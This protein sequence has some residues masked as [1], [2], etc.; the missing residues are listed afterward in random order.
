MPRSPTSRRRRCIRRTAECWRDGPSREHSVAIQLR[1]S[2]RTSMSMRPGS[3]ARISRSSSRIAYRSRADQAAVSAK[4]TSVPSR[5]VTP[6]TLGRISGARCV[7]NQPFQKFCRDACVVTCLKTGPRRA[8]S[9][10]TECSGAE[11]GPV[12]LLTGAFLRLFRLI[13]FGILLGS[14]LSKPVERRR[15]KAT[16]LKRGAM[17]AGLPASAGAYKQS[18]AG[19]S[20]CPPGRPEKRRLPWDIIRWVSGA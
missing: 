12:L 17:T 19:P 20:R 3:A 13:I 7:D 15:R 8:S 9:S 2:T 1:G 10:F 14:C 6:E 18:G 5:S 16:G 4:I 11:V